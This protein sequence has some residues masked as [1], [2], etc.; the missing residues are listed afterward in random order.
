MGCHSSTLER[1]FTSINGKDILERTLPLHLAI[2]SN[3][4]YGKHKALMTHLCTGNGT[5]CYNRL[6][7]MTAA[8]VQVAQS[9]ECVS[10]K[11]QI[12]KREK[13]SISNDQAAA[14][15]Y[16]MCKRGTA[17]ASPNSGIKSDLKLIQADIPALEQIPFIKKMVAKLSR[18]ASILEQTRFGMKYPIHNGREGYWIAAKGMDVFVARNQTI[19]EALLNQCGCAKLG[20][21]E[22]KVSKEKAN[23]HYALDPK[24]NCNS[25][26][27]FNQ[28]DETCDVV[29][30]SIH[31]NHVS[32]LWQPKS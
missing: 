22:G 18:T 21:T 32:D 3:P 17:E 5:A 8:V 13:P 15:A 28:K 1:G 25:C 26:K 20:A 6:K 24:K 12:I 19:Q 2:V 10:R 14:I 4:A 29:E 30:G 16:S 9:D 7:M 31:Y 23:Y 11:I 27:F